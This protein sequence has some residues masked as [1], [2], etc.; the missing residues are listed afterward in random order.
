[1]KKWEHEILKFLE[2]YLKIF[3][4]IPR[5][6]NVVLS[7]SEEEVIKYVLIKFL[8]GWWF[9]QIDYVNMVAMYEI[10]KLFCN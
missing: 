6:L 10:L 8:T 4:N 3:R 5:L 2:W 1:M 9:K 7:M